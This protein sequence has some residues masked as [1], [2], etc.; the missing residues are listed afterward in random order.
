MDPGHIFA[1]HY[2]GRAEE[3]VPA[4]IFRLD[5]VPDLSPTRAAEVRGLLGVA[6]A[7]RGDRDEAM[8][9]SDE[10]GEIT[11]PYIRGANKL[12]QARIAATLGERETA[13]K[14]LRE[15][16]DDGQDRTLGIIDYDMDLDSL[17]DYQ[18]FIDLIRP[19]R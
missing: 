14:L 15:A 11:S 1:L 3:A 2:A 4:L 8:R 17:R 6:A 19:K 18:P 10:I 7:K 5:S 9:W 12:W 16:F 13:V